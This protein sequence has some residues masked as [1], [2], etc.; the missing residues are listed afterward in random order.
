[1]HCN[2]RDC[3]EWSHEGLPLSTTS[4]EAAKLYD[5][6]ITQYVG[7]YDDDTFGGVT[8]TIQKLYEADPNFVMADVVSN[9]LQLIGTGRSPLIDIRLKNS[10]EA[11][12]R[13]AKGQTLTKRE[14][15]HVN[16]VELLA[17]GCNREAVDVWN[18]ILVDHPTD[19]LALRFAQDSY[20]YLGLPVQM[21]DSVARVVPWWK[22]H[23]P[24]YGYMLGMHS[25]GLC[26]TCH[27]D[28][29]EVYARK[30]LEVNRR[31]GWS[32]HT[33][34]HILDAQG[35]NDEGIKFL[36]STIDDWRP[37][38][39][40][41]CHNSFHWTLYHIE[42]GDYEG[43]LDVWDNYVGGRAKQ[44]KTV[45]NLVDSCAVLYRLGLEGVNVGDRWKD[46]E[47]IV[48]LHKDCLLG[49]NDAHFIMAYMGAGKKD[50]GKQLLES[51]REIVKSSKGS[52]HRVTEKVALTL[53]EALVAYD[54]GD[55]AKAVDLM[56]PIKYDII[57]IGG[58]EAQRDMF[59]QFLINAAIQS[60]DKK[61]HKIA[62]ILVAEKKALNE[63]SPLTDRLMQK[64]LTLHQG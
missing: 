48:S 16:A 14:K 22:P 47:S 19:I 1:M 27:Y 50:E 11:M 62:R 21:R 33:I 25:F 24:L 4:N 46:L 13:K 40:L 5:A 7:Y 59:T 37:K 8:P 38:N 36:E 51:I 3:Q 12:T 52:N 63:K 42:K 45:F 9:G 6:A 41:S 31:D 60:S 32:T 17:E 35:R 30:G 10:L 55:Y 26:E 23:I 49:I 61:H 44:T 28:T 15:L 58:S 34:L 64:V 43:A 56:W 57:T 53:C 18:E 39:R 20:I 29:A 54:D 2:W